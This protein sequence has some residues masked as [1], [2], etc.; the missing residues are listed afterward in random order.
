MTRLSAMLAIAGLISC[1]EM[2]FT[3]TQCRFLESNQPFEPNTDAHQTVV[4]GGGAD[5]VCEDETH[6]HLVGTG[7]GL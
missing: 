2:G 3:E 7:G 5:L 4:V 6:C 1:M